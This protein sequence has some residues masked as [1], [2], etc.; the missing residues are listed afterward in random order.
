MGAAATVSAAALLFTV[1]P[2]TFATMR[3]W[4]SYMAVVVPETVSVPVAVPL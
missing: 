3:N 4:S 1:E 2:L